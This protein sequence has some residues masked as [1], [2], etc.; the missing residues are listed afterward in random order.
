MMKARYL[1]SKESIFP[2]WLHK[3]VDEVTF[4]RIVLIGH[5]GHVSDSGMMGSDTTAP[6]LWGPLMRK[7]ETF[8][9]TL[10]K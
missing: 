5:I 1:S 10:F 8:L 6:A 3:V 2:V 4:S 7:W 9:A